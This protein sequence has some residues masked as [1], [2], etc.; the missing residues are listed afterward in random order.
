MFHID[1]TISVIIINLNITSKIASNP[2]NKFKTTSFA[3]PT[4]DCKRG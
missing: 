1:I 4:V 2:E 3:H